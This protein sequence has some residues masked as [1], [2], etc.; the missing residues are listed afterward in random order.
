[1]RS[2]CAN[3]RAIPPCFGT[4][5]NSAENEILR[6]RFAPLRM[7]KRDDR[8]FQWREPRRPPQAR[9]IVG[10]ALRLPFSKLAGGAPA[11]QF[12]GSALSAFV[13]SKVLAFFAGDL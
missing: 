4:D 10:Q 1:M 8:A 13:N 5:F 6:L 12:I 9:L 7:T 2:N 3:K 11:L